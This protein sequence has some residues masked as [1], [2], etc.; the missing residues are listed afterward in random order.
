MKY[1]LHLHQNFSFTVNVL[2]RI[3][4]DTPLFTYM[5]DVLLKI[6]FFILM[7]EDNPTSLYVLVPEAIYLKSTTVTDPGFSW[8][9]GGRGNSQSGCANLFFAENC[10]KMKE[11][12]SPGGGGGNVQCTKSRD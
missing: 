10:M 12:G 9:G 4:F 3:F 11:F 1:C 7:S 8:G 5:G 2:A 6:S